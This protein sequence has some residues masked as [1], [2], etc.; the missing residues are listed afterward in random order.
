GKTTIAM[1]LMAK[2]AATKP[3]PGLFATSTQSLAE[4]TVRNKIYPILSNIRQTSGLL[5][6]RRWWNTREVRL[7]NATHYVAWSG[8]DTQLADLSVFYGHANEVDKWS[9]A[10]K[11]EGEAGDGDSLD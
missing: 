8:S 1:Q 9:F 5:P 10:E 4:R 2:S 7:S 11:Q 6:H 3:M